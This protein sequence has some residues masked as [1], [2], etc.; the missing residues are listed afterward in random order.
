[1]ATTL[2]ITDQMIIDK[3]VIPSF[4]S[5]LHESLLAALLVRSWGM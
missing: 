1:M 4:L 3:T 2:K 5:S